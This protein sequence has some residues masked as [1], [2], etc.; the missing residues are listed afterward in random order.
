MST[1][2]YDAWLVEASLSKVIAELQKLRKLAYLKAVEH[3]QVALTNKKSPENNEE[4]VLI[5]RLLITQFII[6]KGFGVTWGPVNDVSAV[7]YTHPGD[8]F[9]DKG[10]L[11]LQLFCDGSWKDEKRKLLRR[12]RAKDYHYQNS[13]DKSSECSEAQWD[14]RKRAWDKILVSGTPANDGLSYDVLTGRGIAE[15]ALEALASLYPPKGGWRSDSL[16]DGPRAYA[17]FKAADAECAWKRGKMSE[18]TMKLFNS[19]AK[20][21]DLQPV[22]DWSI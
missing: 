18:F 13:T 16:C 9:T 20:T 22:A 15:A 14:A 19:L 21:L 3:C 6:K 4:N 1:R 2:I 8:E 11:V 5:A 12:L 17:Q 10:T 7:I